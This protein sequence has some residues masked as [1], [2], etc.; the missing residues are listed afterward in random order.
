[1]KFSDLD[2]ALKKNGCV[3]VP[4]AIEQSIL[5]AAVE[6]FFKFLTLPLDIKNYIDFSISPT[7]R[8]GDIDYKHKDQIAYN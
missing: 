4:F 1:M 3:Q 8:R 7:H 5:D 2:C 6:S